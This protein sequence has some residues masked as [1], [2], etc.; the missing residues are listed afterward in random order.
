MKLHTILILVAFLTA[1][2]LPSSVSSMAP[3]P[4]SELITN[5]IVLTPNDLETKTLPTNA[6][7]TTS[8]KSKSLFSKKKRRRFLKNLI[9][10]NFIIDDLANAHLIEGCEFIKFKDGG[11]IAIE[12][13]SMDDLSVTYQLCDK[14]EDSRKTVSLTEVAEIKAKNGDLIFKNTYGVKEGKILT[15]SIISLVS[16]ILSLLFPLGL[17]LGPVSIVFGALALKEIKKNP[18]VA[19][20]RGLALASMISGIVITALTVIIVGILIAAFW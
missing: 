13:I 15:F 14:G 19:E 17:L 12:I 5:D 1:I 6:K 8:D 16:A 20:G 2:A 10:R 7:S 9:K 4:K 3:L 18:E 11:K